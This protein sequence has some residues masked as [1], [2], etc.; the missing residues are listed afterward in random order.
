M[1]STSTGRVYDAGR[2]WRS[3]SRAGR[4]SVVDF[5]PL[6]GACVASA[7]SVARRRRRASA[8]GV[9]RGCAQRVM[10]TLSRARWVRRSARR[11]TSSKGMS[12]KQ[13]VPHERRPG[14]DVRS[15]LHDRRVCGL[16]RRVLPKRAYVP[17]KCGETCATCDA[18][19]CLSCADDLVLTGT[20]VS[21][22]GP[23]STARRRQTRCAQDRCS[24]ARRHC[25][26]RQIVGVKRDGRR[27][28]VP[29]GSTGQSTTAS[30]TP[31]AVRGARGGVQQHSHGV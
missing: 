26:S 9:A 12:L 20:G 17:S 30:C 31:G 15:P 10:R 19:L 8:C 2:R 13:R 27:V 23:L 3:T 4:V 14:W 28:Q 29:G 21:R 1:S 18:T 5:F 25:G 7:R 11:V 16:Q 22:S 24:A 6:D